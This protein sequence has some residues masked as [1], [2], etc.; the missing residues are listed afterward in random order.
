MGGGDMP[1]RRREHLEEDLEDLEEKVQDLELDVETLR[2]RREQEGPSFPRDLEETLTSLEKT[3]G[4][5]LGKLPH[6]RADLAD[7][8]AAERRWL[9]GEDEP[10][11]ASPVPAAVQGG[12]DRWRR[13]KTL[14][15]TMWRDMSDSL[16]VNGGSFPRERLP[17]QDARLP[18]EDAWEKGFADDGLAD[19]YSRELWR[20][21]HHLYR[22]P[23]KINPRYAKE[24]AREILQP[25]LTELLEHG[26]Y[27]GRPFV[28]AGA[29][30]DR[31]G[32]IAVF[33]LAVERGHVEPMISDREGLTWLRENLGIRWSK[34]T[35]ETMRRSN[36]D[37][38]LWDWDG[39]PWKKGRKPRKSTWWI[40]QMPPGPWPPKP[41]P[42]PEGQ[43][44]ELPEVPQ[45]RPSESA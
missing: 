28:G 43:A 7:A 26:T 11:D 18:R 42:M 27:F 31:R 40:H 38:G 44:D 21:R 4:E 16:I 25:I 15:A 14:R 45:V 36:I 23:K 29:D 19:A 2:A 8:E 13:L 10:Q 6:V 3:L 20:A 35:W 12:R 17:D 5:E 39:K 33:S 1:V 22:N 34:D 41:Q 30:R 37:R 32:A 9:A 24:E